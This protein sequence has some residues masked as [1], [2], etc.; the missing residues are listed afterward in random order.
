[1]FTFETKYAG[2]DWLRSG[3]RLETEALAIK[4]ALEWVEVMLLNGE[5]V[6]VRIVQV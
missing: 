4:A 3:K 5:A 6:S 2:S 1:M